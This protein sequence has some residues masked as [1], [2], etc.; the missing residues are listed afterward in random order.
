MNKAII[1]GLIA[2]VF[3]WLV[4]SLVGSIMYYSMPQEQYNYYTYDEAECVA[5]GLTWAVDEI[6]G[7]CDTN[8][9]F[10]DYYNSYNIISGIV[11]VVLGVVFILLARKY[12]KNEMIAMGILFGGILIL[13]YAIYFLLTSFID[14]YAAAILVPLILFVALIYY[15]LKLDGSKKPKK[16]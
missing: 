16:K 1:S 14:Y 15:S 6:G 13:I 9:L 2:I 5:A 11:Y 7:Y 10:N 4:F 8:Y 3:A 12:L